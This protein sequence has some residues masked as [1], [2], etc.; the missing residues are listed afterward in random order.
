M[1]IVLDTMLALVN[2]KFAKTN[3]ESKMSS[4]EKRAWLTIWTMCPAY[5]VYFTIHLAAPDLFTSVL[6][7]FA[8]LGT[9]ATVHAVVYLTG[10]AVMVRR[11]RDDPIKADERDHAID[12]RATRAAYYLLLTGTIVAGMVMPFTHGGWELVNAAL[13]AI[14]L[15]ETLHGVYVIA[16]YRSSRLAY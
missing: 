2:S 4:L 7:R 14:V 13:L 1:P 16:S 8:V 10:L 12:A 9:A 6:E 3:S 11:E 15:A 5:L